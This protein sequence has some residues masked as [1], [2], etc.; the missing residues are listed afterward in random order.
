MAEDGKT[1]GA[2]HYSKS[3][4]IWLGTVAAG[5]FG[6]NSMVLDGQ[7]MSDPILLSNLSALVAVGYVIL[8]TITKGGVKI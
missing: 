2:K 6:A 1:S 4:S 7:L 5:F 8:R 3:K